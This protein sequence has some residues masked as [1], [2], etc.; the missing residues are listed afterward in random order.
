MSIA[1]GIPV[2]HARLMQGSPGYEH[3]HV[4]ADSLLDDLRHELPYSPI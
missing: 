4:W 3:I 1:L 2:L